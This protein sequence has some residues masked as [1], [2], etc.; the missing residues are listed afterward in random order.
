MCVSVCRCLFDVYM[1]SFLLSSANVVAFNDMLPEYALYREAALLCLGYY[2]GIS[3]LAP[4]SQRVGQSFYDVL[5]YKSC[6]H[7]NYN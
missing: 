1:N 4:L 5:V 3:S 7:I 2:C 6:S